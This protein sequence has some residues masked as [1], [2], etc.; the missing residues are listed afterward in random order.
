MEYTRFGNAGIVVSR[1]CWGAMSFLE[2]EDEAGAM[3][4]VHEALD[5]GINF[6]DTADGYGEGKSEEVLG[7]ALKRKRDHVIIATKLWY[8]MYREDKNG[9]GCGRYH[10]LRAVDDSLRRLGTDRIDLYMLHHPDRD[11]SIEETLST[12][13]ALVRQGKVRYIGVANHY[14]WQMAHMLGV[15]AQYHW[16]P[17]VSVQCRFNPFDRSMENETMHFCRRFNIAATIYGPLS[18][19]I[20]SGKLRRGQPLPDGSR[21]GSYGF[22]NLLKL[23]PLQDE[24]I[25][26]DV[27]EGMEAIARKYD[28][29]INQLTMKWILSK[30]WIT[31]P[32]LGGTRSEHFSAMYN[33][34]DIQIDPVDFEEI[35]RLTEPFRYVPFK[36]QAIVEGAGEQRNW[37]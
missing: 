29:G 2:R 17:I 10:M 6:F 35:D 16:E 12:L 14:A 15:A 20:L 11:A 24:S 4:M 19:G 5:A 25:I 8:H 3:R 34:F 30:D 28:V 32:I 37:W 33:I 1:F 9:R 27:L 23:P 31:C 21:I 7:K 18:G 26:Y 13:D 36:N 22:S